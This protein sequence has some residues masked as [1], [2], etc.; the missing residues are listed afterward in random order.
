MDTVRLNLEQEICPYTLILAIKRTLE[1]KPQLDSGECKLEVIVD[2]PPT[3]DNFPEE[4]K[5]R[6]YQT[7]IQKLSDAKWS[8]IIKK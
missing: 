8:V 3:L 6:G 2:H 7:E 5:K 4:F 1:I